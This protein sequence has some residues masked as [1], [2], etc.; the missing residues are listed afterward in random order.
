VDSTVSRKGAV[1]AAVVVAGGLLVGAP[2]DP[3]SA[4]G[5]GRP[6]GVCEHRSDP[7]RQRPA[8]SGRVMVAAAH[9]LASEV[10]CRVLATGG[11]AAD[12]AV[13]VQMVLAVVEPQSS[14]LGGGTMITYFDRRSR[15]VES[16][17]G[18]SAAP[19]VVTAGLRTPTAAEAE[20]LGVESFGA[21]V[22][23]TGRAVG[24]PGTVAVLDRLHRRHGQRPWAA[25][26]G[27]AVDLAGGGFGMAPYLHDTMSE[28]V[29]GLARCRYPDL[30]ARY[31]RDGAPIP[32]GET[33]RNT[34][35]AD[36]LR[37]VRDGGAAAFYDPAGTIAP[38][39]A[40]RVARGPYKL[41]TDPAGPAAIPGLMTAGDF[42]R[43]RAVVRDPLCRPLLERR[44][45]TAAPPSFGG[46][47]VLQELALLDR[48]GVA[49]DRAAMPPDSLL[50]THYSIEASRLAQFDRREYVGDPD[51]EPAPV[52]DLLADDYLDRRFALLSPTGAMPAVAPGRPGG[53]AEATSQVSIVDAAGNALSMTTTV[54]TSFGAQMEARGI[55]LN[56]VQENFTR[57]DS[58]SP[59]QRVNAMA[60]GRRPRTSVA[61]TL[62][63][64]GQGRLDL[65]VGA[66]G[67][68]GI[69]DYVAQTILGVFVD[70]LDPQAAVA[71]PHWSGQEIASNCGGVVGAYSELEEGSAVAG[72]L[73]G[74]RDLR[75]PCARLAE[76]RSGLTAI[77]VNPAGRLAGASDPRRDGIAVGD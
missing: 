19:A 6:A 54:N 4:A 14:G 43:Y 10:G 60:P 1:A 13:A 42:G 39:I 16:Y 31:C 36:V 55:A 68:S 40:E 65:V 35:L 56:N 74:L 18:L 22:T 33:V 15:R 45:C 8:R 24:V 67:G 34:E 25:L 9:P 26:F 44:I 46:L 73:G 47:S 57:P 29:A 28:P 11:S 17:D 30:A 71:E 52:D 75:H 70:G 48:A 27:R 2:S 51:H 7:D 77:D 20:Q 66:A 72:L 12:A 21:D 38:A 32:V 50:R 64:D 5:R 76:L 41:D 69:P 3:T 49:A 23:Y 63:F 62:V 59:G 37:E 53:D 58:I 61:P